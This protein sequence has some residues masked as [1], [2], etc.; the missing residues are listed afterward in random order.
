MSLNRAIRLLTLLTIFQTITI[1]GPI[2]LKTEKK[3]RRRVQYKMNDIDKIVREAFHE[4]NLVWE[5]AFWNVLQKQ[6]S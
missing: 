6:L 1:L 5:N 2:F 4:K 3:W